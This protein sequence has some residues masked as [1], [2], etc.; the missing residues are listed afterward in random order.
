MVISRWRRVLILLL[1]TGVLIRLVTLKLA[2]LWI[3]GLL[4]AMVGLCIL[5]LLTRR[6]LRRLCRLGRLLLTSVRTKTLIRLDFPY[7][8]P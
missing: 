2:A 5:V 1:L 7:Q 6:L 3:G 4:R 8:S